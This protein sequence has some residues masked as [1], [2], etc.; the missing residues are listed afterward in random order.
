MA[1]K[2]FNAGVTLTIDSIAETSEVFVEIED[3]TYD[4]ATGTITKKKKSATSEEDMN[5]QSESWISGTVTA[6]D[7]ETNMVTVQCD[8]KEDNPFSLKVRSRL[9]QNI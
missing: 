5:D 4:E 8:E 1:S 2:T 6:I 3:G 9:Q 7:K